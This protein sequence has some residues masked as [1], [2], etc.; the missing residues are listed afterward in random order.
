MK[1]MGSK[2]RIAKHILPI[3]LKNRKEN[4]YWVEP[5]VGGA[6]M[7]DKVKGLRIGSDINEN[8]ILAL[9]CIQNH[10]YLIPKDNKEF[11]EEDYKN[12]KNS[13]QKDIIS[14][15][16]FALSYG[17]KWFGGW[18]RDSTNKR[19]YINEAYRNA[20]K[21][22]KDLQGI[23]LIN[24]D[25][26]SLEIPKESIIYC[27]IPYKNTTKYS[28]NAFNYKDFWEWARIKTK[29]GHK[30]FVSEYNAPEDFICIWE[31]EQVSSLTKDTGSKKAVEKLFIF[32][33]SIN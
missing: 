4:Q 13:G 17:G 20:V 22:H 27:D 19:D 3:M 23:D 8:V 28:N 16:G 18:R 10:L 5:F 11:T 25:Y 9:K 6:N 31:K 30:V 26:D 33:E 21:Q 29:E 24:C 12:I 2:N 32:K 14:Y 15:V 7:I 1:F